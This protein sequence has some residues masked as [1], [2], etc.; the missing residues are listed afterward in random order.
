MDYG[1]GF[2]EVYNQN[3]TSTSVVITNVNVISGAYLNFRYRCQNLQGWSEYS[4]SNIIVAA[5]VP[6]A[7]T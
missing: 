1:I 7:P 6:D 2:V 3:L 5:T 4:P